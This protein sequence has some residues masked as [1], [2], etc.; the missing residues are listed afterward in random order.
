LSETKSTRS[1]DGAQEHVL[2]AERAVLAAM[3]LDAE[4]VETAAGLLDAGSFYLDRHRRVFEAVLHL[5]RRGERADI[6]TTA[7][8]LQRRGHLGMIGGREALAAIIEHATAAQ[9][10]PGHAA[11]I[12]EAAA[13]RRLVA[14]ARDLQRRAEDPSEGLDDLLAAALGISDSVSA[15]TPYVGLRQKSIRVSRAVPPAGWFPPELHLFL[16]AETNESAS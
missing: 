8:E 3:L 4:A 11:I 16:P 14:L 13:R 1:Q 5:H 12:R 10:V 15:T 7:A 6:I 9:N 2:D